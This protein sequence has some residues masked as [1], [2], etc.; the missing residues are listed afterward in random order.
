L[1]TKV[2]QSPIAP[3]VGFAGSV[4]INLKPVKQ[5]AHLPVESNALQSEGRGVYRPIASVITAFVEVLLM[6]SQKVPP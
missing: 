6:S 2:K 5:A 4:V 3:H 1:S